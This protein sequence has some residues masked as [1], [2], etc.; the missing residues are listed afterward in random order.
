MRELEVMVRDAVASHSSGVLSM[1]VFRKTIGDQLSEVHVRNGEFKEKAQ[2][3]MTELRRLPTMRQMLSQ[4]VVAPSAAR[5]GGAEA[6][7][8]PYV[9]VTAGSDPGELVHARLARARHRDFTTITLEELAS[10]AR[11]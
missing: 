6:A 8:A 1:N 7:R 10:Y 11:G 2:D 5:Q 3:L 4:L 9:V